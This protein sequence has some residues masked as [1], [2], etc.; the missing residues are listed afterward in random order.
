VLADGYLVAGRL[1]AMQE[2]ALFGY[3]IYLQLLDDIQDITEDTLAHTKTL[4]ACQDNGRNQDAGVNKTVH[5]GRTAL[6]ELR[7]FEGTTIDTMLGLMNRSIESMVIESAGLNPNG[8]SDEWLSAL[9][10]HSPLG[11]KYIREKK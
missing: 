1:T 10:Q 7:C 3:G 6:E 2:R 4:F 5:F 11:F 9:E 8:F